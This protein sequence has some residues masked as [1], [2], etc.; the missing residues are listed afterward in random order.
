MEQGGSSA[1]C[2]AL[3]QGSGTGPCLVP[4]VQRPSGVPWRCWALSQRP[5]ARSWFGVFPFGK[6]ALPHLPLSASRAAAVSTLGFLH[7]LQPTQLLAMPTASLA[8][9]ARAGGAMEQGDSGGPVRC[10]VPSGSPKQSQAT[11][12]Q[13]SGCLGGCSIPSG[14]YRDHD[15]SP[16]TGR[17]QGV[18]PLP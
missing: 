13:G 7:R 11:P 4:V 18:V 5:P 12:Q 1:P 6:P 15:A 9:A 16:C 8:A 3:R 14:S 10:S 17:C 2:L